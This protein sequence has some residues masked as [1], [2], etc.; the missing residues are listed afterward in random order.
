MARAPYLD[1]SVPAWIRALLAAL[2]LS[3]ALYAVLLVGGAE[4]V[5]LPLDP[6]SWWPVGALGLAASLACGVRAA[7]SRHERVVWALLATAT[8]S[9]GTGF[10]LW[11]ALYEN[12]AAP[13]YPSLADAFWIPFVILVF[14]ALVAL[15]RAE[16]P[17]IAPVAWLDALI[18]ACAVSAVVSQLL[19]PHVATT[20]KPLA[21]QATLLAYPALD[22][23]LVVVTVLVLALGCW[24]PDRAGAS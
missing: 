15:M 13:P 10:I 19:L 11:A 9:W 7:S 1:R 3:A 23:L 8:L 14:A 20:G 21:E 18:P 24:K 16:R 5:G 6:H 4:A 22:V 2:A 12:D 17:N